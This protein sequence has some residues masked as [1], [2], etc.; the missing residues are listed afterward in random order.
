MTHVFGPTRRELLLSSA[1][2]LA[3]MAVHVDAR[4][5]ALLTTDRL[6]DSFRHPP[7]NSRPWVYW[8]FMD[9]NLSAEGMHADLEAMKQAGIGGAIYLEVNL[10]LKSGPVHFMSMEWQQLISKAL[11]HADDLGIEIALA[12]GPGWCGT[13]GPWVKPEDAMQVLV[14]SETHLAGP[15][16]FEGKLTQPQ[17]R[18]PFFGSEV[19]TVELRKMWRDFYVD[20]RVL[21]FRSPQGKARIEDIDEKALYTRGSYSSH[22]LGPAMKRPWVRPRLP[23][24]AQYPHL[25][26][27][28]T[29]GGDGV[30][31]LTG[32]MTADGTLAWTV[33]EGDWTVMRFGRTLTAATTRPAPESGLGLETDK[34]SAGAI[35]RHIQ[36]YIGA[37]LKVIAPRRKPMRGLTTLHF[38]S[39]EMGSQNWSAQYQKEFIARRGYDP[40]RYL[41][42]FNGYIV[43]NIEASERFLWDIRQTAQELVYDNHVQRLRGYAHSHGL[44]L[45][46]EPYDLNPTSDMSLGRAADVPM[47]EFWS[48]GMGFDTDFSVI[49][50]T[51]I[52]HT[53]GRQ[54]IGGEAFTAENTELWRQYPASV[55]EQ[56]DWAFCAGINR[57][58]FHRFQAQAVNPKAPGMTMGPKGGYGVHWD[59]TQTWW[60]MVPDYHEYISRCQY[61]LRR[62]SFVADILYLVAEGAPNVFA[63]P[64]SAFLPGRFKDRR[65]HNFDGCSPET[66]I[67]RA[68]V[69][70]GRI[71][72]PD[73]ISYALL[74]LPRLETMTIHLL[75]KIEQL[76]Y[77]GAT[78][79]GIPPRKSPG[80]S[81]YPD[82]DSR[83]AATADRLWGN[84]RSSGARHVGKGIVIRDPFDE[85]KRAQNPLADARWIWVNGPGEFSGPKFFTHRFSVTQA[86]SIE[87]AEVGVAAASSFEVVVNGVTI[88]RSS[89]GVT[90]DGRL[91]ESGH[92][93]RLVEFFDL[94]SLL[95]DG[96]NEIVVAVFD[97]DKREIEP[98][99]IATVVLTRNDQSMQLVPSSLKWTARSSNTAATYPVVEKGSFG[100]KPWRLTP[101]SLQT[102]S[103]YPSYKVTSAVLR[104]MGIM[105]DF[106]A[107]D[108]L[109]Y[110]HRTDGDEDIYFISNRNETPCVRKCTFRVTGKQPEWWDPITGLSRILPSFADR[111]GRTSLTVELAPRQSG[112]VVFRKGQM[113]REPDSTNFP[114]ATAS[115]SIDG[116]WTVSFAIPNRTSKILSMAKLEDWSANLDDEIRYHSGQASYK[117]VFDYGDS[118]SK[119]ASYRLSLG[120]V[121][122]I[123]RVILNGKDLGVSW[124]PPWEVTVPSTALRQGSNILEIVVANLWINRLIGDG[125]LP[126][127]QHRSWTPDAFTMSVAFGLQP[128]GLLGPVQLKIIP[129]D[130]E[131]F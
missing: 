3:G 47:G 13:G 5:P 84:K 93:Y 69:R 127:D 109:R 117:T 61:M 78:I 95:K 102:G 57:F 14:G 26:A 52:G 94:S 58:V 23:S 92:N 66:L 128:S 121:N 87:S 100:A 1:V 34:F 46:M 62:G 122:N 111:N 54:I 74:V 80:L 44:Q 37:L 17:P 112:F 64:P 6:Y 113:R 77:H 85:S 51:S 105:P 70:D 75:Q 123:A 101:V 22:V 125:V 110:I 59:R 67:A 40:T 48:K 124:C 129:P 39:W 99:L 89:V 41:P 10:G 19:L 45:S 97:T 86:A 60:E 8:Y 108:E 90:A 76:V 107:G 83:I 25:D 16:T 73:G 29:V 65:G 21:A 116:P 2:G 106:E 4:G 114:A 9:G 50:A 42:T 43:D 20:D 88:G 18:S 53:N 28:M 31:D 15:M 63:P 68:S 7:A 56:G 119:G 33:P 38:D 35:D 55:K 126:A 130:R 49:E 79:I 24:L 82:C 120:S 104:Q 115:V 32:R 11:A 36:S 96:E 103:L 27:A 131:T 72:F 118:V 12:T 71:V 30:I 81:G 91:I 98:G